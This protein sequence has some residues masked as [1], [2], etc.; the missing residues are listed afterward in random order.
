MSSDSPPPTPLPPQ[1]FLP[2]LRTALQ[3]RLP[4]SRFRKLL[5]I[6]IYLFYCWGLVVLGI[7]LFWI[8]TAGV[9]LGQEPLTVDF[10]YSEIRQSQVRERHP[11]H[12]DEHFDVLL[13]GGSVLTPAWGSVEH[14]LEEKFHEMA[15]DRVRIFNLAWPAHTSRDSLIKYWLVAGEEFDLVIVYDGIND[16]AMNCCPAEEF[17][18]DYLHFSWYREVAEAIDTGRM[19]LP[20]RLSDQVQLVGQGLL[21]TDIGP[22]TAEFGREIKTVRTLRRNHEELLSTA[23]ARGDPVLLM[24]FAYNIPLEAGDQPAAEDGSQESP[25]ERLTCWGKSKYVAAALDAQNAAIRGLAESH[26]DVLFVDQTPLMPEGQGLFNDACHL[27]TAGSRRFVE[28]LWP[29]VKSRWTEW[30]A[31]QSTK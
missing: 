26:P 5:F 8:W 19:S 16:V 11:R 24:T 31:S 20:I 14:C 1:Q 7:K 23:A 27:S 10:F 22:Q 12:S 28:N 6:G 9:P 13:L 21:R 18:D 2:G 15:G 3:M 25:G 4:K 29:T 30:N 17:R